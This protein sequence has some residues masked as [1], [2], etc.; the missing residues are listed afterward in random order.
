MRILLLTT[1]LVF[2]TATAANAQSFDPR[3]CNAI[4][5]VDVPYDL[6]AAG[7]SIVLTNG[8]DRITVTD[9]AIVTPTGR[10]DDPALASRYAAS[11]RGFMAN[12]RRVPILGARFGQAVAADNH[13]AESP[14]FLGALKDMCQS[15]LDV[16]EVQTR[17]ARAL[18]AFTPPIR[19]TLAN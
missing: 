3:R 6:T 10:L 4:R 12:A 18:P 16:H 5:D 13:R 8:P 11:L 15:L 14:G 7:G 19:V 9:R 1:A 17:I 2:A